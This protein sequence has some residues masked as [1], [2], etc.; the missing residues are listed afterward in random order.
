M[1]TTAWEWG[2]DLKLGNCNKSKKYNIV[3]AYIDL[4]PL[5]TDKWKRA[6]QTVNRPGPKWAV[7]PRGL[8][9]QN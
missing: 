7:E 3:K 1:P 5:T 6:Q 4:S 2:D 8:K 9:Y